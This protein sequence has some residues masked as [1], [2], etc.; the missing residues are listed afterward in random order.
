M[1]EEKDKRDCNRIR[2]YDERMSPEAAPMGRQRIVKQAVGLLV[3]RV[4]D[5]VGSQDSLHVVTEWR[6]ELDA[7]IGACWHSASSSFSRAKTYN[8]L[9]LE[10]AA[11]TAT[12]NSKPTL[13]SCGLT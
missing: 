4:H 7:G 5:E 8:V 11:S 13:I 1:D 12:A 6:H 10:H 2:W 3:I 9:M